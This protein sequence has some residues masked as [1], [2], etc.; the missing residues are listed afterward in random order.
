MQQNGTL[1]R[2][3]GALAVTSTGSERP[4]QFGEGGQWSSLTNGAGNAAV[5]RADGTLWTWGNNA[6]GELGIGNA[7]NG[8]GGPGLAQNTPKPIGPAAGWLNV[9][10][11]F[12]HMAAVRADGTLWTWGNNISFTTTHDYPKALLSSSPLLLDFQLAPDPA[13]VSQLPLALWPNPATAQVQIA[14]NAPQPATLRLLNQSGQV[15]HSQ[16]VQGG[17][18]QLTLPTATLVRGLYLVQLVWSSGRESVRL[19]L[20]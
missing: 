16:A 14:T 3:G 2:W 10:A 6:N 7:Y 17:R 18:Q 5:V 11:G 15:V 9:S 13:V 20:L 4:V 1:W 19:L 12:N 8:P